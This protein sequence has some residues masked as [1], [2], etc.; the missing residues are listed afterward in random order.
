M[1]NSSHGAQATV[2]QMPLGGVIIPEAALA[3]SVGQKCI[4]QHLER[5]VISWNP[6]LSISMFFGV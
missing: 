2:P 4:C 3:R 1:G 6:C 5:F